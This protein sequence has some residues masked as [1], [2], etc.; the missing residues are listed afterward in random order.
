MYFSSQRFVTKMSKYF[1]EAIKSERVNI[2]LDQ[3]VHEANS[4]S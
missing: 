2:R 1:P 3:C 4:V